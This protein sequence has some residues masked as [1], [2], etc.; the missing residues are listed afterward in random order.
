MV[1]WRLSVKIIR[2]KLLFPFVNIQRMLKTIIA[3][4]NPQNAALNHTA[5][6]WAVVSFMAAAARAISELSTLDRRLLIY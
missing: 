5:I 2:K 3:N 6:S 4:T 1:I